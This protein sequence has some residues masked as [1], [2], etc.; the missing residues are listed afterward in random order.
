MRFDLVKVKEDNSHDE[1]NRCWQRAIAPLTKPPLDDRGVENALAELTRLN[2]IGVP[3]A[4]ALLT[5]WNPREFGIIDRRVV[6][7]LEM[8]RYLSGARYLEFLHKLRDIRNSYPELCD[9]AL[10]QIELAL[11]HYFPLQDAGERERPDD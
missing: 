5:A 10:R 7:V 2:G 9:C 4:S 6:H 8:K 11:W 3:R 1:V